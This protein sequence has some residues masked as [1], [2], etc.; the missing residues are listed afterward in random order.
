[1]LAVSHGYLGGDP[2]QRQNDRAVSREGSGELE[3]FAASESSRWTHDE[4]RLGRFVADR[5]AQWKE[6][7]SVATEWYDRHVPATARRFVSGPLLPQTAYLAYGRQ[8]GEVP[9][10]AVLAQGVASYRVDGI[11]LIGPGAKTVINIDG[12]GRVM[13]AYHFWHNVFEGPVCEV[14]PQSELQA[15]RAYDDERAWALAKTV[16][17]RLVYYMPPPTLRASLVLP[18]Y[19]WLVIPSRPGDF[20]SERKAANLLLPAFDPKT[21]PSPFRKAAAALNQQLNTLI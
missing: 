6:V 1:M 2:W 10:R 19:Q 7:A 16:D 14:T 17:A 12:R 15:L 21:V 5:P 20:A 11:D 8:A 4:F 13:Q 3:V 18:F 9:L